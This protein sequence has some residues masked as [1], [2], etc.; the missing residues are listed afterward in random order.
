[1]RKLKLI[2]R[3]LSMTSKIVLITSP[4]L[5]VK[6]NVSGIASVTNFIIANNKE[7]LYKHFELGKR[8]NEKRG[9]RWFLK[10]IFAWIQWVTLI[11]W[12]KNII[13]H[14]NFALDK[15]SVL[16]DLP[17]IVYTIILNKK[18]IIHLHGG[19][20]ISG[21]NLP[22]WINSSLRIIFSKENPKIVLSKK[23]KGIIES[24]FKAK[25]V[26]V[27][28]NSID[29]YEARKFN[30]NY[31]NKDEISLLFIGRIAK[32]KGI[33]YILHALLKLKEEG[34]N[35]F[36]YLAGDGPEKK[37]YITRFSETLNDRFQYEGIVSGNSKINLFKRCQVFLLPSFF[38]GLPIS[39]IECM[40]FGIVPVVTDVGSINTLVKQYVNGI[41]VPQ[42]SYLALYDA[43]YELSNNFD[44]LKKLASNAQK[45]VFEKFNPE[46]YIV[47]LNKIYALI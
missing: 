34:I 18:L 8:D 1:M 17:L 41:F 7:Y 47:K 15:R 10:I 12:K 33:E 25:N 45:E 38:E 30:R 6:N 9:I 21:E 46:D 3:E 31:E 39:L 13:I 27:L 28:P 24:K 36:F 5:D 2:G 29:L 20:Y 43:V 37:E 23:E 22:K 26:E 4:S 16:R 44:L 35:F 19:E 14:F 42:K 11:T 40:S 32:E